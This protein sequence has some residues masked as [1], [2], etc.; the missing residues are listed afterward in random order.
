MQNAGRPKEFRWL[1]YVN[2]DFNSFDYEPYRAAFAKR[3]VAQTSFPDTLASSIYNTLTT[4]W[5]KPS[6][7]GLQT[8]YKAPGQTMSQGAVVDIQRP[9]RGLSASA[10]P[11]VQLSRVPSFRKVF[12]LRPFD[13][14][15]YAGPSRRTTCR[16]SMGGRDGGEDKAALRDVNSTQYNVY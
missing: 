15:N 6:E 14:A 11:Y 1:H 8:D 12:I 3:Y 16:A 13:P 2:E 9:A 5:K 4:I 10:S 7:T